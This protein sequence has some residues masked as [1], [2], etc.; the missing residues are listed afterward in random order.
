MKFLSQIP[1]NLENIKKEKLKQ[2]I[3]RAAIIAKLDAANPYEQMASLT[4]DNHIK[5]DSAGRKLKG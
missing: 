1:I 2:E 5:E 3:F 4:E